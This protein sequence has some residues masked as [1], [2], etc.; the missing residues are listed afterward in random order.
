MQTVKL[1][2]APLGKLLAGTGLAFS[3]DMKRVI[4]TEDLEE[5][6]REAAAQ[7]E[8]QPTKLK[9]AMEKRPNMSGSAEMHAMIEGG[10]PVYVEKKGGRPG[11]RG[12]GRGKKASKAAE[13]AGEEE[14]EERRDEA[15]RDEAPRDEATAEEEGRAEEETAQREDE[16]GRT[17]RA[18]ADQEAEAELER[19]EEKEEEGRG[20]GAAKEGEKRAGPTT[21]RNPTQ[22]MAPGP[23]RRG[24]AVKKVT[25]KSRK[26]AVSDR[27][28]PSSFPGSM[29]EF[30][31]W[32]EK[33]DHKRCKLVKAWHDL[34]IDFKSKNAPLVQRAPPKCGKH[35]HSLSYVQEVRAML[36]EVAG[37]D[38]VPT[39]IEELRTVVATHTK[40]L[41]ERSDNFF[42]TRAAKSRAIANS[43]WA[44]W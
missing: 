26:G 19:E 38:E 37:L 32:Q 6:E 44:W 36:Q 40:A 21:R 31:L 12:R 30:V 10:I 11:G 2:K 23:G 18:E 3:P 24:G 42:K 33:L 20:D 41:V 16:A 17:S 25:R 13:E 8:K 27:F 35:F 14:E 4:D 7:A 29:V 15:P 1:V 34:Y 28:L 39:T 43:V 9:K 22:D 5:E